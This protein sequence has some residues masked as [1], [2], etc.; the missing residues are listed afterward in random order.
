MWAH[1]ARESN[2]LVAIMTK[3]CSCHFYGCLLTI[4]IP[5]LLSYWNS[6]F[7]V[8]RAPKKFQ[9]ARNKYVSTWNNLLIFRW[10]YNLDD[11]AVLTFP[12]VTSPWTLKYHLLIYLIHFGYISLE[13][14]GVCRPFLIILSLYREN[15]KKYIWVIS[16]KWDIKGI[17]QPRLCSSLFRCI[18]N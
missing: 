16:L 1:Q 2:Y 15:N 14:F 3:N 17:A 12:A 6:T 13:I 18:N 11:N 7:G 10:S 5:C 9:L 8:F 4:K